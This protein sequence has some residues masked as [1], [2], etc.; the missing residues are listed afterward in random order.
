M[1]LKLKYSSFVQLIAAFHPGYSSATIFGR[2][3]INHN[4]IISRHISIPILCHRTRPHSIASSTERCHASMV[5]TCFERRISYLE[6]SI[7]CL[8]FE[9]MNIFLAFFFFLISSVAQG[10]ILFFATI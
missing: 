7:K 9:M 10:G 1:K 8:I 6:N 5:R 2:S 3:E 4:D